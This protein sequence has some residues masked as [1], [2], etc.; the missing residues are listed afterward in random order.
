MLNAAMAAVLVLVLGLSAWAVTEHSWGGSGDDPGG[1]GVPGGLASLAALDPNATPA[2]QGILPSAD[3]CTIQPLTVD[4]V[5]E[6]IKNAGPQKPKE[7]EVASTPVP[8]IGTPPLL[9][10]VT[11]QQTDIDAIAKVQREFVACSIKGD[12][13]Q[14]WAF[15]APESEFW[16][17]FLDSYPPFADETTV[18]ADIEA[19]VNGGENLFL[20]GMGWDGVRSLDGQWIPDSLP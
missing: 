17:N 18:R 16:R 5:M 11:P 9:H 19:Y 13:L 6:R 15:Y 12:L 7:G 1:A 3:E 14:V 2:A 20:P 10:K 4:Q 8:I